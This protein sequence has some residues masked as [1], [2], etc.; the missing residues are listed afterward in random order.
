MSQEAKF[1]VNELHRDRY[2]RAG[3][4]SYLLKKIPLPCHGI[5]LRSRDDLSNFI[6]IRMNYETAHLGF[7]VTQLA[8][9]DNTLVDL[10]KNLREE[11]RK[12]KTTAKGEQLRMFSDKT[13]LAVEPSTEFTYFGHKKTFEKILSSIETPRF[14]KNYVQ[15]LVYKRKELV[16][17]E[18]YKTWK[19][20]YFIDS[21]GELV[22]NETHLTDFILQNYE[23][24]KTCKADMLIPP[25]PPVTSETIFEYAKKIIESTSKILSSSTA[26]YLVLHQA[27]LRDNDLLAK[28][29][30]FYSETKLP[31][32]MLKLKNLEATDPDRVA[33]TINAFGKIQETFCEIRKKNK[34]KCTIL[35]EGGKLT[36]PSLVRGFDIVT[37]TLSGRNKLGGGKRKIGVNPSPFSRYY[38]SKKMVFFQYEKMKEYAKNQLQSTNGEHAL[39]CELPCC[40]E[41]KDIEGITKSIWNNSIVRPHFALSMN[42]NAKHISE[43]IYG[44]KIQETKKRLLQSYLCVLK[45]LIP[46]V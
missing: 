46:D 1:G 13:L 40:M 35:L 45:D 43:M 30:K 10:D 31:I 6:R 19:A 5:G 12:F 33:D 27:V 38:I 24:Q 29:L 20:K 23:G 42:D 17:S 14:L 22:S 2:A 41:V 39:E 3:E 7:C 34:F 28:I 21:W 44:D 32:L 15:T 4:A 9:S 11:A 26:A 25:T 8:Y 16:D 18:K 37:N 36:Y